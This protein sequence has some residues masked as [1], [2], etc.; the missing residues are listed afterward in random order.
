[1][2]NYKESG[3]V[4]SVRGWDGGAGTDFSGKFPDSHLL[5]REM[6]QQIPTGG[7][8][9]PLAEMAPETTPRRAERVGWQRLEM[10]PGSSRP[11]GL[12]ST[13]GVNASVPAPRMHLPLT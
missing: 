3:P 11:S 13:P 9:W 8:V 12:P 7:C 2:G 6:S 10:R 5:D 4:G 1:M